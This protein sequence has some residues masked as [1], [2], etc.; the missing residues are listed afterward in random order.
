LA[1][2]HIDQVTAEP[3]KK[4]ID[5]SMENLREGA[6]DFQEG[7]DS[8]KANLKDQVT[9]DFEGFIDGKPFDNGSGKDFPLVLGSMVECVMVYLQ[10]QVM[11]YLL[12]QST[13]VSKLS[14]TICLM[15]A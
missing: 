9:I 11:I 5:E 4:T 1:L 14:F 15:R 13:M 3:D 12:L 10:E 8:E 7:R 6:V 2:S